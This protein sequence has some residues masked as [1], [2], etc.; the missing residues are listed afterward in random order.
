VRRG[1]APVRLGVDISAALNLA[2]SLVKY[3]GLATL[4]PAVFAIAH[5][6]PWWPFLAAGA[7]VSGGTYAIQRATRGGEDV[8]VREGYLV[9]VV[10]WLF[11]ATF[12]ALPYV[13]SGDDQ[14]GRPVDALFEAM[15]GFTTTGASVAKDPEVLPV[16]I[17]IWRQLTVWLGGIGVIALALAVL[18]RL[19]VGGRQL[20]ENELAGPELDTIPSRITETVRRFAR[21]YIGLTVVSFL[22]LALPGWLGADHV[23][24]SYQAFAHALTTL[25]TG[26]FSTETASI[27]AF[28]ALT[29]WTIIVIMAVGGMNFLLLF[30]GLI[31]R[32]WRLVLRDEEL[33]WY[34]G[35]L[36]GSSAVIAVAIVTDGPEHGGVLAAAFEVTSVITTT[37]YS[38]VDY[39]QWPLFALMG[40][41]LLFFVGGCA[42]STAGS[43]KVVRHLLLGRILGREVARTVHPELVRPVRYNGVVVDQQALMAVVAFMLIYVAVFVVGS[44]VIA[45]DSS[46][47]GRPEAEGLDLIFA[48][49]ST[50]GNS[51]V[52]LG[53]AGS[54]SFAVY[55][56]P[57]TFTMTLLMWLGRLEILPVIV[58]L[59]ASYWRL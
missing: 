9:I 14:L 38:T 32:R 29:Q 26:G 27:G 37:G 22:A 15:S 57:S 53:A 56:D 33:R 42:G 13:L 49:A 12:G 52:G 17:Q 28:G 21:L 18:P 45:L 40:L 31:Q 16:S 25:G 44:G 4:L 50:L 30:R 54:G 23:M 1:I 10:I 2:A 55:G 39:G 41:A 58:L 8:G 34:L 48:S 19:R 24:D 46:F 35:I 11:V 20:L 6:E 3:I 51:G 47:A 5:D 59:R 43:I 7:I 36:I